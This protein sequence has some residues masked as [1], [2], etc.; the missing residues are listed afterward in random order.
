MAIIRIKDVRKMSD[1]DLDKKLNEFRLELTK[2]RASIAIGA[3]A[4]SPGRIRE[5]RRAIARI[6]TVK[7]ENHNTGNKTKEDSVDKRGGKKE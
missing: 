4:T 2:E 6:K 7:S 5:I 1:K 3:S